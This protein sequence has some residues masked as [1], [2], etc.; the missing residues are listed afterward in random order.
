MQS[1]ATVN[2]SGA[3]CTRWSSRHPMLPYFEDADS[4]KIYIAVVRCATDVVS[5]AL[6]ETR[7]LKAHGNIEA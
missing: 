6:P 3:S 1:P 5:C 4:R 2:V 7:Y